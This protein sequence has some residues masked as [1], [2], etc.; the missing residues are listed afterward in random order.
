MCVVDW[1]AD[2]AWE[3][4]YVVDVNIVIIDDTAFMLAKLEFLMKILQI[5]D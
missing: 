2:L 1:L 5:L 3:R 4:F